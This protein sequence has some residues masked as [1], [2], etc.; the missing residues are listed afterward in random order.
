MKKCI[1]ISISDLFGLRYSCYCTLMKMRYIFRRIWYPLRS[2]ELL[3]WNSIREAF[4]LPAYYYAVLHE[5][6]SWF[7][8][9]LYI[10][11]GISF[12]EA[13]PFAL[14]VICYSYSSHLLFVQLKFICVIWALWYMT[15]HYE[16]VKC[17]VM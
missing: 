17:I 10:M 7:K 9:Y 2:K 6:S 11:V 14:W 12:I 5:L 16:Q 1:H 15:I 13:F 8:T 3:G 4:L